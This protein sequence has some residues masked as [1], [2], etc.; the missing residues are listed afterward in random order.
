MPNA[1]TRQVGLRV[2]PIVLETLVKHYI[3]KLKFGHAKSDKEEDAMVQLRRE[4]LIYDEIFTVAFLEAASLHPVEEVQAFSNTRTI[5]PPWVHVVRVRVPMSSCDEAA[6]LLITALG[7]EAVALNVIGG[8]KWWQ[9]RSID[10]VDAQWITAKKDWQI[11]KEREKTQRDEP[12]LDQ[13]ERTTYHE[14]MD[15]MRC[16]LYAHGPCFSDKG[17]GYY[18]GSVDQERY[19]IQRYA[20]KINGRVFAINYRLAPQ[21]PFPCAIQDLLAAYLYLIQP[22]PE[23]SHRPVKPSHLIVAGDSAGGGLTLALLQVLR[24]ASLPLPA[25]AVLISPWC[26]LTHSF[27]SIHINTTTDVI[28]KYGLSLQ[29]PSTLWPPPD[30]ELAGRV[31]I[32]LRRRVHAVFHNDRGGD[33]N[34]SAA[35]FGLDESAP[36]ASNIEATDGMRVDIGATTPLPLPRTLSRH[37]H[38][39][40]VTGAQESIVMTAQNGEILTI[41]QQIQLYTTNALLGHPLVSPALG[42]LGGLPPLLFIISD[43]EV[44]RDEG[45]YTAHKAAHPEQFPVKDATRM[46]YPTLNGIEERHQGKLT[47]VHLQVY[48]DVAHV[49]PVLFSFTTPAKFCFRSMAIFCKYV[50]GISL[51]PSN[52]STRSKS[53][54][55]LKVESGVKLDTVA[56]SSPRPRASRSMGSLAKRT[57]SR[58]GNGTGSP[59]A[60]IGTGEIGLS[61]NDS[62]TDFHGKSFS[63]SRQEKSKSNSI[64]SKRRLSSKSAS[65]ARGINVTPEI[66][67]PSILPTTP[68]LPLSS[69]LTSLPSVSSIPSPAPPAVASQEHMALPI[70]PRRESQIEIK[71]LNVEEQIT[72]G[73]LL[74]VPSTA[75]PTEVNISDIQELTA[76][77]A[78]SRAPSP[79]PLPASTLFTPKTSNS[80]GQK[81]DESASRDLSTTF[82]TTTSTLSEIPIPSSSMSSHS[83]PFSV[84]R[85]PGFLSDALENGPAEV[86][87]RC[88]GD[89]AVYSDSK[90]YP[91]FYNSM[92]RER[93]STRGV[94][95]PLEPPSELPALAVPVQLIGEISEL[96]VR[97]YIEGRNFYDIKFAGT[98]KEIE[99]RRKKHL[100][101]ARKDTV[102]NMSAL[103]GSVDKE[104]EKLTGNSKAKHD[105]DHHESPYSIETAL[106]ASSGWSWSWALDHSERPPP[107]SL[108]ARRDTHEALMLA[109]IADQSVL[110]EEQVKGLGGLVTANNLWS[111]FMGLLTPTG[112]GIDEGSSNLPSGP[113]RGRENATND[114]SAV[115]PTPAKHSPFSPSRLGFGKTASVG[116][117]RSRFASVGKTPKFS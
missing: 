116:M 23:A 109:R 81:K 115:E 43:K 84:R 13:G 74:K 117:F 64:L 7:G 15:T 102:K 52:I 4:E 62:A 97:R 38:S 53:Q 111:V 35:S 88:A 18:F 85:S 95:R 100:K 25:G 89:P 91:S 30:E 94:I 107:S 33:S 55:D 108:V 87:E 96:A 105:H 32:G 61:S 40:G 37:D 14:N 28:P 58:R 42:Y 112:K 11:H 83:I 45:I 22:P 59:A 51:F 86:Q 49:L 76:S 72:S 73:E 41:H 9:V 19:S 101:Q 63:W 39:A 75:S 113:L 8:I 36:V 80:G 1:L 16:I 66:P 12:H 57:F 46:L 34:S 31:R 114:I 56:E 3:E 29:K 92:I 104:R 60:S 82:I 6:K 17:G 106:L 21:Y 77:P 71:I 67:V 24:D 65:D 50:T 90:Q 68:V 98:M 79:L 26:D 5:S 48:D 103:Q 44:L 70:H 27:P 69:S 99:K 20:R 78:T 54:S 2:G 10:G 47:P 93:V 110:Q